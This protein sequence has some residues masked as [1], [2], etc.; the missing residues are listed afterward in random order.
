VRILLV[1]DEVRMLDSMR[2]SLG[3]ERPRWEVVTAPSGAEAL[4][5]VAAGPFQ[6]L[7]T[8]MQMPDLDGAAVLREARLLA[9]GTVRVL[10]SGHAGRERIL[11]CEGCFHQFLGKPVHPDGLLGVLDAF[12]QDQARPA[13]V[14]ARAVV[15][16]LE[17][18]PSLPRIHQDLL[19]HLE[20]A[21][22]GPQALARLVRQDLGLASRVLKRASPPSPPS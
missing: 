5:L 4:R 22:P 17:R 11:A 7:V 8:D 16:G 1:D 13:T 3:V 18:L 15:A 14:R 10:L 20:G 19:R 2:R 9:P 21:A 6:V 12:D